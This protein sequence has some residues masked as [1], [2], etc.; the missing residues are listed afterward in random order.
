MDDAKAHRA[1]LHR[2]KGAMATVAGGYQ[3]ISKLYPEIICP[4]NESKSF[5][6]VLGTESM[7]R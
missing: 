1:A 4:F 2:D 7:V 6:R 5:R 3:C